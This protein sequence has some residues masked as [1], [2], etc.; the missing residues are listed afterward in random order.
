[1]VFFG[2]LLLLV[3]CMLAFVDFRRKPVR[4]LVRRSES[5]RLQPVPQD[6][7]LNCAI[8]PVLLR[9][10]GPPGIVSLLQRGNVKALCVCRF[11]AVQTPLPLLPMIVAVW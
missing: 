6:S 1:M 3:S 11:S 2:L 5:G 4:A 8:E 7:D 10:T 9:A